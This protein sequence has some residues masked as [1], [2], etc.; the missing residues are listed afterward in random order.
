MTVAIPTTTTERTPAL[1]YSALTTRFHPSI[2]ENKDNAELLNL[3]G[4][5]EVAQGNVSDMLG[6]IAV[7]MIER[8]AYDLLKTR[9]GG[10]NGADDVV[11]LV[12]RQTRK[13]LAPRLLKLGWSQD[14]IADLFGVTHRTIG[15]DVGNSPNVSDLP[16][17]RVDSLGRKQPTRKP[18]TPT[19]CEMSALDV[20]Q[21][22]R[23]DGMNLEKLARKIER[24]AAEPKATPERL[25]S[26]RN[27]IK[28]SMVILQLVY[29][30]LAP[31]ALVQAVSVSNT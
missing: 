22:A 27:D 4:V 15:N 14:Q 29:D 23:A 16:E 28:N 13:A 5:A 20:K 7:T 6:H 17:H 30:A 25:S 1:A 18:R 26:L 9:Y 8:G 10:N 24:L 11:V 12:T 31:D 21:R 2:L 3:Y 19:T